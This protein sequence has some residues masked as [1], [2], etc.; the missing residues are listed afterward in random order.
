MSLLQVNDLSVAFT[1]RKGIARAVNGVGFSLEAGETLCIVGESGSGKS[2]LSM[3]I[4]RLLESNGRITGGEILFDTGET[5]VD[6]TKLP[7]KQ[8]RKIRGNRISMVFQE[9]MTAL[10]PVLSVGKQLSEP[11]IAHQNMRK[12]Q[13]LAQAKEMLAQVRIPNPERVIKG[14][15]H[16]LSGGMRQRVM[17]AMALA[18]RPSVLI[19][20]EPTTALDVTIQA[21]ILRLMK[22]LQREKGTAILF[23]T[24]DLGV[25]GEIADKVAVV[26]AGEVVEYADKKGIFGARAYLHP[27]TQAL[28]NSLPE[29]AK[30]GELLE[31]IEGSVPS[32]LALP[33]GCKF[34]PRCKY[35]TQKCFQNHPP[36]FEVQGGK[37]VRCFYPSVKERESE[38]HA[39]LIVR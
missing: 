30:A 22:E 24:H 25:V 29:R 9:P 19:A 14:Y 23:I 35:R 11:F 12:K 13:A 1:T 31:S 28:K 36:L 32:P 38:K 37:K 5:I 26:Y 16:Q 8:M 33:T 2:V 21:Q 7:E 34:A 20:D 18:C 10:N 15:P 27:Y 6:L 3:S 4:L 17:I 39:K